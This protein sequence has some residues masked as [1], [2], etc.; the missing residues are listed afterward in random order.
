MRILTFT[1]FSFLLSMTAV[2]QKGPINFEADGNGAS[3]TWNV[4]EN[5]TNPPLEFIDNPSKT[6]INTTDKVA[7]FTALKA[8]NPWAGD[9]NCSWR[10]CF[11]AVCVK[12]YKLH[13]K[14][15]GLEI[16]NQ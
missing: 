3:W 14:N 4:F 11:R 5:S 1:L 8:G 16:S 9:R 12:C 6:G 13:D 15:Y 10:F 2:C 7:K